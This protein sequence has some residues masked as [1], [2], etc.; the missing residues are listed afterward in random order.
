[1]ETDTNAMSAI[2]DMDEW[3]G[4]TCSFSYLFFFFFLRNHGWGGGADIYY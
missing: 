4:F 3:Y 2:A 1:M